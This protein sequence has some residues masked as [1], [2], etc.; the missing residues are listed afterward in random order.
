MIVFRLICPDEHD[1]EGWFRS[2]ADY[3]RQRKARRVLCPVCGSAK[4]KK[5]VMAPRIN[6]GVAA[7]ADRQQAASPGAAEVMGMLRDLR[8]HIEKHAENVGE[9]LPEEARRIH[10]GEAKERPIYGQASADDRAELAD[11]GIDVVAIPWVPRHD[12]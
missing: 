11:E 7:E 1:F 2:S 9:N 3:D 4:V 10:Y 6:S 5:G 8:A 12:A